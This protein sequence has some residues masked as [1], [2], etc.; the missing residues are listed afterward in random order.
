M[1]IKFTIQVVVFRRYHLYSGDMT[2]TGIK[3]PTYRSVFDELVERSIE[4]GFIHRDLSR[5]C[6]LTGNDYNEVVEHIA[7]EVLANRAAF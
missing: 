5:Y 2:T 4:T 7:A 6:R 3:I 1:V